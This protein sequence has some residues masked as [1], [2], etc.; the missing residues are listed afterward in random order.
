[1]NTPHASQWDAFGGFRST[2]EPPRRPGPTDEELEVARLGETTVRLLGRGS[3]RLL[4]E[5]ESYL[6][7]FAIA[8]SPA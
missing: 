7:F 2:S 8:R 3:A 6:E 1:M 5:I 4:A